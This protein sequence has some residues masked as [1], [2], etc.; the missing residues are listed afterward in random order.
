VAGP[1]TVDAVGRHP[2][3]VS[4]FRRRDGPR[5]A[6]PY[7][8]EW[9]VVV[10]DRIRRLR[11][12]RGWSLAELSRRVRKPEGG[13]YSNGYFSRLE[14]GWGSAPLY[15]YLVIAEALDVD[16]GV[17]LGPDEVQREITP[18]Q[19]VLLRF[20]E[21]AGIEPEAAIAQLARGPSDGAAISNA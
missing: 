7:Y 1:P 13:H 11:E 8:R 6:A 5:W 2:T 19:G 21:H 10:G 4:H 3:N 17:L 15:V 18:A 20:L 12:E 9:S 16:P 14:R